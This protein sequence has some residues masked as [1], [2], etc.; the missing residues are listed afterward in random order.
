MWLVKHEQTQQLYIQGDHFPGTVKFSDISRKFLQIST[1]HLD[2]VHVSQ[3]FQFPH[4]AD[5]QSPCR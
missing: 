1:Y 2:I 4:Y 3:L 5:K